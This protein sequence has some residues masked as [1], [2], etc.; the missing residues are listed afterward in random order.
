MTSHGHVIFQ[1][2]PAELGVDGR[3][4]PP[5][6]MPRPVGRAMVAVALIAIGVAAYASL[7]GRKAPLADVGAVTV[8]RLIEVPTARAAALDVRDPRDGA[9]VAHLEAGDAEFV[10]AVARS[11]A[12]PEARRTPRTMQLE[13][14]WHE[15]GQ[16]TVRDVRS[17][18]SLTVNA[19]GQDQ[20]NRLFRVLVSRGPAP[21]PTR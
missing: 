11:L 17:G 14:A 4:A 9:V 19:F 12:G 7:S 15:S 8:S 10:R 13:L 1:G 3:P 20:V 16:L 2:D 21:V 6:T 18:R 5:P